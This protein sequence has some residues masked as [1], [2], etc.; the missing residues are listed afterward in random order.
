[1]TKSI[2]EKTRLA[3]IKEHKANNIPIT[4]DLLKVKLT[5]SQISNYKKFYNQNI[6][7]TLLKKNWARDRL[8]DVLKK[9]LSNKLLHIAQHLDIYDL[10]VR[11]VLSVDEK[12]TISVSNNESQLYLIL[13]LE[14]SKRKVLGTININQNNK[15]TIISKVLFNSKTSIP[16]NIFDPIVKS[17]DNEEFMYSYNLL[18]HNSNA[19]Y[20]SSKYKHTELTKIIE[21]VKYLKNIYLPF[22][23]VDTK[24]AFKYSIKD[25]IECSVYS[26]D[27][28]L[29]LIRKNK[30]NQ[31]TR[32]PFIFKDM[33]FYDKI[34][35]IKTLIELKIINIDIPD[36]LFNIENLEEIENSIR[37]NFY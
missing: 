6:Q 34:A 12:Y 20:Y 13:V 30:K 35:F 16:T 15:N 21:N 28:I 14:D 18:I 24:L 9:G 33:R 17:F 29:Q 3:K 27:S 5:F 10:A 11:L 37:I 19:E 1:M 23:G 22:L 31:E 32:K 36:E 7:K 2:K 4:S 8:C 25:N 26:S